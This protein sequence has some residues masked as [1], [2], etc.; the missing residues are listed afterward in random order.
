MR[1]IDVRHLGRE[2]VIC[3]WRGRRRPDRP[4]ARS[5]ASRPCWPRSTGSARARCCSP[6]STSITPAPPA[7]CAALAG[8]AGLGARARRAAPGRPRAPASPARRACTA[9]RGLARL[10]GEVVPVPEANLRVLSGGEAASRARSASSTRPAT[11]R[12]T[13]AYLH[14]PSGWAFAG[15]VAGVR[16]AADEFTLAADAAARHRR[17]GLGALAR[18]RSPAGAPSASGSRTSARSTTRC[19]ARARARRAATARPRS[20]TRGPPRRSR[21]RWPTRRAPRPGRRA[22]RC[23]RP[24]RRSSSTSVLDRWRRKRAEAA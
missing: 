9:A 14:E 6:T 10:W 23:S 19:A 15:D 13:S 1:P 8:A 5:R 4:R 12:T 17:R 2:H 3:C 20:P 22:R 18:R 16:D 21:R 11:P 24:R 7:R